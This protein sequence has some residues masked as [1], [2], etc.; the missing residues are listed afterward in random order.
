MAI[1]ALTDGVHPQE[2]IDLVNYVHGPIVFQ[3]MVVYLVLL[4]G[5]FVGLPRELEKILGCQIRR[6]MVASLPM[7]LIPSCS[8]YI[9]Y[10]PSI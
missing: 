8:R 2:L 9:S 3:E 6:E 5:M 1:N 7:S 10:L 4:G